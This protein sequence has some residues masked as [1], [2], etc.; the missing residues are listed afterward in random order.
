MPRVDRI[1]TS[2]RGVYYI[3]GDAPAIG[4]KER[5]YYIRYRKNGRLF[6]ELV[7]RQFQ[8]AMTPVKAA[9]IRSEIIQ[10]SQPSR[11]ELRERK[12][13]EK[14]AHDRLKSQMLEQ[15]LES[16]KLIEE[17]WLQFMA[18]ATEAFS[19]FDSKLNLVETNDA[20]LKL[21]PPGTRKSDLI[22]KSLLELAP[23]MTEGDIYKNY[24][25]VIKTGK[26]YYVDDLPLPPDFGEDVHLNLR[27]FKVGDGLG[28]IMRDITKR[29]KA[30]KELRK[31]EAEL[32]DKT[33]DLGEF[34][35]A[36]KVLLKRR[37][38]DKSELEKKVLFSVEELTMPYIKEM[39][40]TRLSSRQKTL[41]DIMESN[42]KEIIS[43][44]SERI[45]EKISKLTPMEI[46]VANLVKQGQATK[47]I[48]GLLYLSTKT[49]DCHRENIR[50][51]IGIKNT[52]INL[53]TYLLSSP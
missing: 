33:I 20:T 11:K 32:K 37:E 21:L 50:K 53:R 7:G 29:I 44:F 24:R 2:Y 1:N 9:R 35:T 40:N 41:M 22:G 39:K 6:E 16:R 26:P 31:S 27:A 5:I 28:I 46:Q 18:S 36:L 10:G 13:A 47:E 4:K 30:E 25:D 23:H 42:L 8:D 49:I 51:K 12:K 34:N 15:E 45:S 17:K 52:K 43:P 48:A 14:Y 38:E 3:S 19:L